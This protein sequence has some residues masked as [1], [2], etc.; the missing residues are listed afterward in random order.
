MPCN[1]FFL[2]TGHV[3]GKHRAIHFHFNQTNYGQ[4]ARYRKSNV[5]HAIDRPREQCNSHKMEGDIF[6]LN[7]LLYLPKAELEL[8]DYFR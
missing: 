7:P 4:E 6:L 2:I 5:F 3:I 1:F 8:V